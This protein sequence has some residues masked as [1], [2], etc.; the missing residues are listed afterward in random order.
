MKEPRMCKVKVFD[1]ILDA[2]FHG[3]FQ[4]S[5]I[6]APSLIQGGHGGG[7][8]ADVIAVVDYGKGLKKV[9]LSSVIEI[10]PKGEQDT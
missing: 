8:I 3:V 2:E 7:V 9:N 1:E 6:L 10:K 5:E 4:I